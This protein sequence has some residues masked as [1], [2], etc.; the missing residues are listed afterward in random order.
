ME[1]WKE[2]EKAKKFHF[3]QRSRLEFIECQRW[4]DLE[5]YLAQALHLK[6]EKIKVLEKFADLCEV[7]KLISNRDTS[8][9]ENSEF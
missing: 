2:R 5:Y 9:H 1:R 7:R 3:F 6:D 4:K 8:E